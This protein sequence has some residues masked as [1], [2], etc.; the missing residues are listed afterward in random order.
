MNYWWSKVK[1]IIGVLVSSIT[2]NLI[3]LYFF[4]GSPFLEDTVL[5]PLIRRQFIEKNIFSYFFHDFLFSFFTVKSFNSPD[6]TCLEILIPSLKLSF[7]LTISVLTLATAVAFICVFIVNRFQKAFRFLQII[8]DLIFSIP[9]LLLAPLILFLSFQMPNLFKVSSLYYFDKIVWSLII[10]SLR[11][12]AFLAKTYLDENK[13][14]DIW[15]V[16]FQSLGFSQLQIRWKWSL[17]LMLARWLPYYSQTFLYLISG[18]FF[19]EFLFSLPGIG[20]QL[21]TSLLNRDIPMMLVLICFLSLLSI[22]VQMANEFILYFLDP[23]LER[24]PD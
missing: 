9:T 19:V 2:L 7:I 20:Y 8:F 1:W 22:L 4:P 10:L 18:S 5:D 11:P 17:K 12:A 16:Y 13:N 21:V 14:F 24:M 15:Q 3:V 6:L 23:R